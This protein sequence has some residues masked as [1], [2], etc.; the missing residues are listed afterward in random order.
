M[1]TA[2]LHVE[3]LSVSF[4]EIAVVHGIS[5]HVAP[6]ETLALVGESGCGKSVTA[7]AIMRLLPLAARIT[8]GGVLFGETDL[9]AAS[10]RVLRGIR[11]KRIGLI[12]QEPMTSLNPVL[13]VGR[14]IAEVI[15]RHE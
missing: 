7:F 5:F 8:A 15:R 14:Q 9:A 4:G 6:G 12:L 1:S 3:G 2:L 11:G 10:P 13:T